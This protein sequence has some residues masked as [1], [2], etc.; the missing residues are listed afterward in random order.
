MSSI[1]EFFRK[2]SAVFLSDVLR[3]HA[4]SQCKGRAFRHLLVKFEKSSYS[5]NVVRNA[6]KNIL[7]WSEFILPKRQCGLSEVLILPALI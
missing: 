7:S 5:G 6:T 3:G 1:S 2:Y 4:K